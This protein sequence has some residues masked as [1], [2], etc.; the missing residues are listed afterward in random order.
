MDKVLIEWGNLDRTEPIENDVFEKSQ[1]ILGFA[2]NA[3]N[4]IVKFQVINPK[5]SAGVATQSVSMELRLPNHQDVRASKE[6]DDLYRSIKEAESAILSQLR[7]K[8]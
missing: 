2:P 4:L 5:S 1:K 8:K 3:T 7:S 6:G